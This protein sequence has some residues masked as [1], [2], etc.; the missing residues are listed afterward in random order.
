MKKKIKIVSA[1]ILILFLN[2]SCSLED[3]EQQLN[4][5]IDVMP[6][7]SVDVDE[8][9]ILGRTHQIKLT[10]FVPSNC[11]EFNGFIYD[12]EGNQRTIAI[13]NTVY[14]RDNCVEIDETNEV[15]L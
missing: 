11:H 5:S 6:I 15:S 3:S 1:F 8:V 13:A 4:F 14:A 12:I 9:F 7:E 10:Y 2:L